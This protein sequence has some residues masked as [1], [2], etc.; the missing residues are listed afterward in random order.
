VYRNYGGDMTNTLPMVYNRALTND[1]TPVWDFRPQPQV[2][3]VN[4]GT[5]DISNGKGDPGA[6]F[7]DAYLA[8]VQTIR[9]RYPGALIV[10]LIGPLLSG[11]EL[12]AIQVHIRSVVTMRNLAGDN[13]IEFFEA[14]AAQTADKAA[15]AYH[16]NPTEN[17][18]M[19]GQLIAELRTR[20][21]W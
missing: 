19:A 10:C 9:A 18:L 3:V 12:T 17:Q 11:A 20:L 2:V 6:P 4:L 8:F 1:A 13:N 15:C 5:N 7:R 21:G 14:I 16:P